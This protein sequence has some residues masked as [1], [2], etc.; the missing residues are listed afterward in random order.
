MS[1]TLPDLNESAAIA[2]FGSFIIYNLL[3]LPKLI[4]ELIFYS[5]NNWNLQAESSHRIPF[6]DRFRQQ[7]PKASIGYIK[8]R[9]LMMQCLMG[10]AP[11]FWTLVGHSNQH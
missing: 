10:L 9:V 7:Y 4:R 6:Q 3:A 1:F 5:K 8:I 2:I 11:I